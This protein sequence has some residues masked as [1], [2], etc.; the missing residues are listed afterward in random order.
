MLYPYPNGQTLI[1][2]FLPASAGRSTLLERAGLSTHVLAKRCSAASS[3]QPKVDV[4][5]F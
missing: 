3:E 2:V 1:W 4:H 5:L